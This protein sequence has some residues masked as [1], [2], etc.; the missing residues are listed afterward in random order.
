MARRTN[1]AIIPAV[2]IRPDVV[3]ARLLAALEADLVGPFAAGIP[4]A[5]RVPTSAEH[6]ALVELVREIA[7]RIGVEG[8]M[9]ALAERGTDW[10]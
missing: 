7:R 5:A 1:D 4:G 8:V 10:W 3:R 6:A 2:T 9:R